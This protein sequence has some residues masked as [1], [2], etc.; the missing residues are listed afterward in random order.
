MPRTILTPLAPSEGTCSRPVPELWAHPW[1]AFRGRQ[2]EVAAEQGEAGP[3]TPATEAASET[4]GS[5]GLAETP[6]PTPHPLPASSHHSGSSP[7]SLCPL[8][9]RQASSKPQPQQKHHEARGKKGTGA[10][11]L[12]SWVKAPAVP[13]KPGDPSSNP[14][15]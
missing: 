7:A 11:E 8:K 3:L 2:V 10:M 1:I 13:A 4:Q 5:T 9:P 15:T 14:R 6:Q 12:A